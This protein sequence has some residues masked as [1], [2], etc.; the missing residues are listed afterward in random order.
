MNTTKVKE[1]TGLTDDQISYLIKKVDA[2]KREK[3]QGKARD[4]SFRDVVFLKLASL[5]RA[6][7]LPISEIDQATINI[8]TLWQMTGTYGALLRNG[9]KWS[10]TPNSNYISGKSLFIDPEKNTIEETN[11]THVPNYYYN[12]SFIAD[13]LAKSDQPELNLMPEETAVK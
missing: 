5:M 11:L 8:D 3:T 6:D 12:I 2:L 1:I 13:E 4:Y 9:D 7:G 10:W